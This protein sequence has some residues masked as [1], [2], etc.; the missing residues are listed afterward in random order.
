MKNILPLFSA[1][2]FPLIVSGCATQ[3][4]YLQNLSVRGPQSQ[5]P[6]FITKDN[7][8]GEF[9]VAPR[10]SLNDKTPITGR[11]TGHSDVNAAGVYL[12]DTVNG[13]G[14]TRYIQRNGINTKT[15]EGQNFRWD[16][17][18]F[19]ASVD[20]EY[21]AAPQIAVVGGVNYSGGSSQQ[22]VG[23]N[24]GVGFLFEGKH[25]ATRVD[26][27]AHW[28][29]I[30]YDVEYVVTTTPLSLGPKETEVAFFHNSGR[31]SHV[32]AYGAFTINSKAASW[33]VQFF[34]QFAITRQTVVEI[35]AGSFNRESTALSSLSFFMITPG[36]YFELSPGSRCLLGVQLRD[37]TELLVG[38]PGLLV[39]PFVQFEFKL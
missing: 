3:S 38:D 10:F 26:V 17:T 30:L 12:V 7:V 27:G 18:T 8:V 21:L 16:P 24:A 5:T 39:S 31:A 15:F 36:L 37:E 19:S 34:A 11:A 1:L 6:L 14:V 32:N 4:V 2:V 33:P 22:F 23:A 13:N 25:L 35:D 29:S 9:T 20:F 28:N